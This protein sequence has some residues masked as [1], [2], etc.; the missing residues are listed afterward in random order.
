MLVESFKEIQFGIFLDF[1]IQVIELFYRGV[2]GE[3]I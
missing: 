3:E 2:A 1:D